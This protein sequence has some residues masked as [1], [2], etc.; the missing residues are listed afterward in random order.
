MDRHNCVLLDGIVLIAMET[1]TSVGDDYQLDARW[2]VNMLMD[3]H[4]PCGQWSRIV[5]LLGRMSRLEE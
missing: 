2:I 4:S 1:I 3:N 5:I